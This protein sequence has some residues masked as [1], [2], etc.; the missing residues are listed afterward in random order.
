[1]PEEP[2]VS[3]EEL[4]ILDRIWRNRIDAKKRRCEVN[5][6]NSIADQILE[7]L[8]SRPEG[9]Q[10][11][12]I[13]GLFDENQTDEQIRQALMLLMHTPLARKVEKTGERSGERFLLAAS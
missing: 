7:A 13:R 11:D 1:M 6:V 8:Q 2:D 5:G 3:P 9:M 12:E 10:W 4:D